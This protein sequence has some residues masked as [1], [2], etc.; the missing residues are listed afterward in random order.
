MMGALFFGIWLALL[1]LASK[2][3]SY[4]L[5]VLGGYMMIPVVGIAHNFVHLKPSAF[6]YMYLVVGFS[7]K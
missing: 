3:H 2:Y 1:I 4:A 6:K 7:P 5:L